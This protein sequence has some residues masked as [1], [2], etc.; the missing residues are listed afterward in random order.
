MQR[1]IPITLYG[2]IVLAGSM[3]FVSIAGVRVGLLEPVVGFILIKKTVLAAIFLFFFSIF[4]YWKCREICNNEKRCFIAACILFSGLYSTAW[5]S[6][7]VPKMDL[8]LINDITTDTQT[9]PAFIT[10]SSFRHAGDNDISYPKTFAKIQKASY[11]EVQPVIT[12]KSSSLV[13]RKVVDLVRQQGWQVVSLYPTAGVIE[14]T[15]TTPVFW[16]MD[17]V[18]VRVRSVDGQTR[19][20]MRSSSRIGNHDF[21]KNAYRIEG[22]MSELVLSLETLNES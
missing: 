2:L 22:F 1:F 13:F 5:L 8:P 19:V 20:D 21:G 15:A 10:M 3:A 14:A 12:D 11:P 7:Y 6:F 17:D 4:A 18:V 9:P 16:F